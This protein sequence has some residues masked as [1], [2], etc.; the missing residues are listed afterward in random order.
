MTFNEYLQAKQFTPKVIKEIVREL[1]HLE[2]WTEERTLKLASLRHEQLIEYVAELQE[3]VTP[4]TIKNRLRAYNHYFEYLK[5]ENIITHNPVKGIQIK[6]EAKKKLN[7]LAQDKLEEI[8][9][10][11]Q[12]KGRRA[13]FQKVLLGLIIYQATDQGTLERIQLNDVNLEKSEIYLKSSRRSNARKLALK[14]SQLMPLY[15]YM[16]KV[17][18]KNQTKLFGFSMSN[19]LRYLQSSVRETERQIKTIRQLR[20]SCIANWLKIYNQREVQ[21]YCGYRHIGSIERYQIEDVESLK[22]QLAE[23]HPLKNLK[24]KP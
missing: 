4:Q 2:S 8:Y 23:L 7:I 6:N 12:P 15:K 10:N 24:M 11:Y 17:K 1:I 16:E 19:Q 3:K 18:V 21:Y 20:H 14:G 13:I 9:N 5:E 22:D